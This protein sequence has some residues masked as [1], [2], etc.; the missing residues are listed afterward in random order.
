MAD[1]FDRDE[2]RAAEALDA[3][4]DRVLGGAAR[5]GTEPIVTLLATAI[6]VDPPRA[7]AS[8]IEREVARRATSL[9]RPVQVAAAAM[10]AL[11]VS[12]GL[13]NLFNGAWVARGIGED[14]SPHTMR[15]GGFA[16]IGLGLVVAAG[17]LRRSWLPVSVAAGAPVG[18]ALGVSGTSEIGHFAAGALLHS[19]EGIAAVALIVTW[20]RVRRYASGPDPEGGP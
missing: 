18:I 10:A 13:G 5:P 19:A 16:L 15:E 7:L 12:Q 20:W 11:L 4:I 3:E 14:F 2:V 17:V 1:A 9:W 8:R 6:R